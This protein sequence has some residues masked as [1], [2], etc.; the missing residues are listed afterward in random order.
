M[1]PCQR[2]ATAAKGVKRG[3]ARDTT[4]QQQQKDNPQEIAFF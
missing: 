2:A 3:R 4:E 1:G